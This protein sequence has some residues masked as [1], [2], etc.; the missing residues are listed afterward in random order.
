MIET[1]PRADVPPAIAHL[2]LDVEGRLD[3]PLATREI[4]IQLRA[5]IELHRVSDVILQRF[6]SREEKRVGAGLPVVMAAVAGDVAAN[7]ALAV[8]A[9]LID[10]DGSR[11]RIGAE[12][13]ARIAHAAGK[14]ENQVGGNG[15][16]EIDLPAGFGAGGILPLQQGL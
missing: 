8:A 3:V 1:Q 7:V 16:L 6:M 10:D 13:E 5:G 11:E 15:V 2:I 14:T 9:I 4:Q 12:R